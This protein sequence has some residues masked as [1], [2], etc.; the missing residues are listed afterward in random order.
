MNKN[1]FVNSAKLLYFHEA[2][3][4]VYFV[5]RPTVV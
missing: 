1:E 4:E 5:P 3:R 2:I